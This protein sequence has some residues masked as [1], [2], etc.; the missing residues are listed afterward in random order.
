MYL[1]GPKKMHPIA[2]NMYENSDTYE[3]D[4]IFVRGP[5]KNALIV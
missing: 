2:M 3:D 4:T 1:E 5:T